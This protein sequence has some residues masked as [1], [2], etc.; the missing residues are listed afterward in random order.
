MGAMRRGLW[1]LAFGF[2]LGG[3]AAV[4]STRQTPGADHGPRNGLSYFLPKARVIVGLTWNE[5]L[6]SWDVTPTVVIEADPRARYNLDWSNSVL[7]DKDTT[8]T[9]DPAT[10]LLQTL[11]ASTPGTNVNTVGA[12]VGAEPN[13]LRLGTTTAPVSSYSGQGFSGEDYVAYVQKAPATTFPANSQIVI[14]D[15]GTGDATVVLATPGKNPVYGAIR[16]RL[17]KQYDLGAAFPQNRRQ[18][19]NEK[20][21]GGGIMV[22]VPIPYLLTVEETVSSDAHFG[23]GGTRYQCSIAPRM[24]MLPDSAHDFLYRV[25]SRPL[26]SDTTRIALTNGMIESLEQ[27]RPSMLAAIIALPKYL[28]LNVVPNPVQVTQSQ[29]TISNAQSRVAAEHAAE[30]TVQV[31]K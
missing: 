9:V 3:C 8:V 19:L 13:V 5:R 2:L 26:V 6:R 10:G 23:N 25:T 14:S 27:I 21:Q 16:V 7:A 17:V 4:T 1:I 29:Q 24:V 22:R 28:I 12:L 30:A 18:V 15:N 20:N 31:D 11:D